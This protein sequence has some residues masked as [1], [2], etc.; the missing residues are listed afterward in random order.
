MY[1]AHGIDCYIFTYL[2]NSKEHILV[3]LWSVFCDWMEKPCRNGKNGSIVGHLILLSADNKLSSIAVFT[4]LPSILNKN[5]QDD[6][7]KV[8]FTT[9]LYILYITLSKLFVMIDVKIS[10]G[11]CKFCEIP[12]NRCGLRISPKS[13]SCLLKS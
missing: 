1:S 6:E 7:Q 2:I 10:W 9:L 12:V 3:V 11:I 5:R 4:A 8:T 13:T